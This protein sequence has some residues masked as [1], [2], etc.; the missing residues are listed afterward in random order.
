MFKLNKFVI[1]KYETFV[2]KGYRSGGLFR[3][4]LSDV[5]NKVVNQMYGIHVFV[6]LTLVA[7]RD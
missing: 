2:V 5:C 7:C 6:M 3:L 4:S 1:S